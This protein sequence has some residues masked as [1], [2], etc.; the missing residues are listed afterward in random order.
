MGK[1]GG[2]AG[3]GQRHTETWAHGKQ[4]TTWVNSGVVD[5]HLQAT[6]QL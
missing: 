4:D 2:A 6:K 5:S 3:K 1:S